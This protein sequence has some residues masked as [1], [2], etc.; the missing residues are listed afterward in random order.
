MNKVTYLA[1]FEK[2]NKNGY[3]VFFP[4]LPG[5]ITVGENFYDAERKAEEALGLHYYGLELEEEKI[6]KAST[7]IK[8]KDLEGVEKFLVVPITIFP[9]IVRNKIDNKRVKT[10]VTL[11]R[12]LK[13]LA[14]ERKVNFSRLLE[15][16]LLEFL[17]LENI[18]NKKI[19]S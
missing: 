18:P 14:E 6:P 5:C 17:E 2:N 19:G 1:V 16:S 10:N 3:G 8:K 7:E 15:S 13:Q 12:W 4:D 9:D 11:P